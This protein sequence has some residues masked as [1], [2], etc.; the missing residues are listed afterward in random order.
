MPTMSI[1]SP[2]CGRPPFNVDIVSIALSVI[3]QL[4][5]LDLKN[6]SLCQTLTSVR[7]H[8]ESFRPGGSLL[9][10]QVIASVSFTGCL[11]TGQRRT[12]IAH[13]TFGLKMIRYA[14]MSSGRSWIFQ[15]SIRIKDVTGTCYCVI[16]VGLR[17]HQR[18]CTVCRGDTVVK[19]KWRM[20]DGYLCASFIFRTRSDSP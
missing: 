12:N 16:R 15:D 20:K 4:V 5:R 19:R 13:K 7:P 14:G 8:L 2:G 17:L 11:D 3:V 18:F 6:S 10:L 9:S 1:C